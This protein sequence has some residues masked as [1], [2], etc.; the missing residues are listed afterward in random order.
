[1]IRLQL[2]HGSLK[3]FAGPMDGRNTGPDK[4]DS[5]TMHGVYKPPSYVDGQHEAL[6]AEQRLVD[7]FATELIPLAAKQHALVLMSCRDSCFVGSCFSKA[8]K[9]TRGGVPRRQAPVRPARVWV[10]ATP[11][12]HGC[13]P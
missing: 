8:I 13:L 2:S 1:M 10:R 6:A 12:R 7:W 5:T 11:R 3:W 9:K 4:G